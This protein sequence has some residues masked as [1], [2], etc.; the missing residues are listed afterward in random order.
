MATEIIMPKLSDTMTEGHFGVWRKSVGEKIERGD[1]LAEI[2]TDKA[3]MD[4]E[5]FT[6]GI[7]LEQRVK[8]GEQVAVGTVI[9]LIG[10]ASEAGSTGTA[11]AEPVSTPAVN[12]IAAAAVSQIDTTAT[13]APAIERLAQRVVHDVQAAPIVRRRAAELGIDLSSLTG[14]GP[15]GRIMLEDLPQQ[16]PVV[17]KAAITSG[18]TV[19]T[20]VTPQPLNRIRSAIAR[21]TSSSW[22]NI[23]HFYLSRD[24]EMKPAE[25]LIRDLKTKGTAVSL[26][27]LIM[28]AVAAALRRFP[29]LNAGFD[30]EGIISPAHVNLGFAVALV[31]G[32]QVPVIREAEAKSVRDLSVEAGKLADK[33]RQGT[34]TP[35]D[36]SGGSFTISNLGMYGVDTMASIIIPGQA[37]ILGLGTVTDRPVVHNGELAVGRVMTATLSCDHRIIDGA[38]AADFLNEWKRVLEHPGELSI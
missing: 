22:K 6:S 5:A 24:V 4:L 17:T 25:Q 7:L 1:I 8:A 9:G 32:L 21:T 13:P 31:D 37:A 28:A 20:V 18:E 30:S 2:E 15:G 12:S 16:A 29:A 26:N 27:A 19:T 23:P 36:I 3:I 35:D 14:S 11:G 34:L 38:A 33:A 10:A